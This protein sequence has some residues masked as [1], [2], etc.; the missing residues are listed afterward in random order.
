M[1]P[2]KTNRALRRGYR[3]ETIL[4]ELDKALS[5]VRLKI[6]LFGRA[7]EAPYNHAPTGK[8]IQGALRELKIH[9]RFQGE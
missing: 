8:R 7:S 2:Q 3:G 9:P 1:G 5:Q 6:H 4:E